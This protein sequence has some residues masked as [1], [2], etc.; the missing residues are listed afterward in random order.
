MDAGASQQSREPIEFRGQVCALKVPIFNKHFTIFPQL[1]DREG[2]QKLG[3]RSP[4]RKSTPYI[5]VSDWNLR[6][7]GRLRISIDSDKHV[8]YRSK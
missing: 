7:M 2:M 1:F 3:F 5:G 8:S 4:K 6:Y